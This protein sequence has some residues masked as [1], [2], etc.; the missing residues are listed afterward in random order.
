MS[1]KPQFY[2]KSLKKSYNIRNEFT[3]SIFSQAV[4]SNTNRE[5]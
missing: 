1:D 2:E 4:F 5:K 3:R